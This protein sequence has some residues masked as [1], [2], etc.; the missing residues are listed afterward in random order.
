MRKLIAMMVAVV[1]LAGMLSFSLSEDESEIVYREA[2]AAQI[3]VE[4]REKTLY[5]GDAAVL[6]IKAEKA[7]RSYTVYWE[8][9]TLDENN[10]KWERVAEGE[11]YT[12]T[13]TDAKAFR[14]VL[15]SEDGEV[16]ESDPFVMTLTPIP[17]PEIE[18]VETPQPEV[19]AP[20]QLEAETPAQT[21]EAPVVQT[22]TEEKAEETQ[23][24]E[25]PAT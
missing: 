16:V 6:Y 12:V 10:R 8:Q 22:D 2:F 13:A 9:G 1:M 3:S 21:E 5:P 14:A 19:T 23:E 4:T 18:V 17:E 25:L 24:E 15:V 11:E 7:N 20:E